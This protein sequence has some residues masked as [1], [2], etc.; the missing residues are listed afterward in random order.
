MPSV[1]NS[2]YS[3]LGSDQGSVKSTLKIQRCL[4][5]NI[6]YKQEMYVVCMEFSEFHE[7][8]RIKSSHLGS[9]LRQDVTKN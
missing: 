9:N 6:K 4:V 5:H 2:T 7:T 8:V 1:Y 3:S